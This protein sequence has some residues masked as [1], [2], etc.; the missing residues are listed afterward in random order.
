MFYTEDCGITDED[1][2]TVRE[3][4]AGFAEVE[5]PYC[6]GRGWFRN[7]VA[8]G[9]VNEQCGFCVGQGLVSSAE[10]EEHEDCLT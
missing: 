6:Y 8:N 5:C 7:V 4:L 9:I 1:F 3:A 2:N 10:I